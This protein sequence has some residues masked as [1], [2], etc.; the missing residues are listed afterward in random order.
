[1]SPNYWGVVMLSKVLSSAILVTLLSASWTQA[2]TLAS[3]GAPD[4]LPPSGFSGQQFI[5][6]RGCLYLRAGFGGAV[7]W[8]PRVDFARKPI[9]GMIPSFGTAEV[10]VVKADPAPVVPVAP[11]AAVAPTAVAPPVAVPKPPVV[12]VANAAP[13][14]QAAPANPTPPAGYELAWTDDRLNPLRGVGSAAGQA[15]QDQIW[16][17]DIPAQLVADQPKARVAPTVTVSTM[18]APGAATDA[19]FV[20]VG[21]FGQPSNADSVRARLSALGL[22]VSTLTISRSGKVL[23]IVYA[24]PFG[25]SAAANAALTAARNA[26]FGDAI[27]R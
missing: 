8:V 14:P 3:I 26:G 21:T 2:Q 15:Q 17:R 11:V 19:A 20:Q 1:M 10:A 12:A 22:P 9:C 7:N 27:L 4:N 18:S 6:S 16:T 23:Q 13:A 25:S 24:G 5:D